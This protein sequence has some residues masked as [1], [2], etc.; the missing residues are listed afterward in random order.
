[1]CRLQRPRSKGRSSER[2]SDRHNSN[3]RVAFKAYRADH[4]FSQGTG[5]RS[6]TGQRDGC[7]MVEACGA[8]GLTERSDPITTLVAEKIIELAERGFRNP[9][10]I[11]GM[12]MTELKSNLQLTRPL[13]GARS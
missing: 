13:K 7:G 2:R 8:L 12:A 9:T 4:T 10:A 11:H 3:Q 6:G 1:M 5:V